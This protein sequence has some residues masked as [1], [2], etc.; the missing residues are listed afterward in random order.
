MPEKQTFTVSHLLPSWVKVTSSQAGL[1]GEHHRVY[2]KI[3]ED[4]LSDMAYVFDS[5]ATATAEAM[6]EVAE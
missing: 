5:L 3:P 2:F 6:K 1:D 4:K